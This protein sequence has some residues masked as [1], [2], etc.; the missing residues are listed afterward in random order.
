MVFIELV[1]AVA[2]FA[3]VYAKG[4]PWLRRRLLVVL[5]AIVAVGAIGVTIASLT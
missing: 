4:P 2:A 1:L 5:G 3:L